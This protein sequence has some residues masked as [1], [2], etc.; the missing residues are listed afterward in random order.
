MR[1]Y[2][3]TL[4]SIRADLSNLWVLCRRVSETLA[5]GRGL[6]SIF[7]LESPALDAALVNPAFYDRVPYGLVTSL[8]VLSNAR[9]EIQSALEK[10]PA[11]SDV[12][13]GIKKQ[14]DALIRTIV[15]VQSVLDDEV[16]PLG[17]PIIRTP[18]DVQVIDGLKQARRGQDGQTRS[19]S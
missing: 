4:N 7:P 2:A 13:P 17:K 9:R 10:S 14:V 6:Q 19:D 16:K 18:R 15:H 1:G 8:I 12:D 5:K 11:P 3:N